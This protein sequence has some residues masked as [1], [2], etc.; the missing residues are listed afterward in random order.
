MGERALE[1]TEEDEKREY[2][3]FHDLFYFLTPEKLTALTT[4]SDGDSRS[5]LT[6][7]I[8]ETLSSYAPLSLEESEAKILP[9][10]N[11][12]SLLEE[13]KAPAEEI[14]A[15]D[16]PSS[17]EGKEEKTQE[18]EKERSSLLAPPPVIK[19]E[20]INTNDFLL[21]IQKKL[22]GAQEKLKKKEIYSLYSKTAAV[23]LSA[24]KLDKEDL[25]KDALTGT[26]INKKQL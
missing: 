10:E 8:K 15:L 4:I 9:F 11:K 16:T 26:L 6:D 20:K 21:E 25:S 17:S 2:S 5:S 7:M 14:T 24:Q 18:K 19:E 12:E 13:A 22:K 3:I 1:E 23:D